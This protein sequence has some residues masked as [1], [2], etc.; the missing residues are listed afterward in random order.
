MKAALVPLLMI[1]A[2]A[3]LHA[4]GQSAVAV[5]A[6][7]FS[8]AAGTYFKAPLAV[9]L[10]SPGQ[11]V[12]I[13]YTLDE[14]EPTASSRQYWGPLSLQGTTIVK[15]RAY[16][17][18][19]AESPVATARFTIEPAVVYDPLKGLT[20]GRPM[21]KGDFVP[22]G[23]WRSAGG[24]IVFDAGHPITDGYFEVTMKGL[25]VPAK[26]VDKTHPLAGW[27]SKNAYGHYMETG[28]F[29]NWRVGSGYEAFKV[30]AASR[31]IGTRV[32]ERV[33]S[34]AEVNDGKP[35]VYR[36]SWKEGRLEFHFDGKELKSWTLDRFQL[37]YFTIGHDLQYSEIPKSAP[38]LSDVK[39]VDRALPARKP[40]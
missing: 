38:I 26:G 37:Q 20:L 1:W 9:K 6:P 32:E 21:G 8:P 40:R 19:T 23:G 14:S 15:A 18:G 11:G 13:R 33:G 30:L 36:V 31:S 5:E 28:S 17:D 27:E 12:L 34:A 3:P 7:Q 10:T 29:W 24:L 22:G 35:H 4:T 2:L 16:R 39:V 25:E